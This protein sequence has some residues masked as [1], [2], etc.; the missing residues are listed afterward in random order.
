[1]KRI[2]S[3]VLCFA[4][5]FVFSSAVVTAADDAVPK[6]SAEAFVLY[7]ADNGQILC[8]KNENKKMK[9]ASTTKIMTSLLALEEA[10][11]LNKKVKFTE[12]MTA[13]GS[14][15]Y[16]KVGEVVTLKD[17]AAGMMM[18]SGNDAANATALT[19]SGST[20]KFSELMNGRANQ[21][22]MRNTHF[23]TPSGLDDD[24][25]YSTAFDMALLMAYALENEEFAQ[26]TSQKSVTVDFIEPA[27]KKTTYSNHNR[28]LSLYKY[29]IGGKTGYTMA[30]GRCL[31]SAAKKDG[32]TLVCVTMNDRN[33][34][35]DHASLYDYGFSQLYSYQ[36]EDSKFCVDVP[37]VGGTADKVA[38]MGEKD[39]PVIV[40]SEDKDKIVRKVYLDS[41]VY[42][43]IKA[44][45][46]V[47]K[48]EY[49]IDGKT[50]ARVNL[51]A[52]NDVNSQKENKSLFDI[53]K[54]L[55][56]YG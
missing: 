44:N 8:S 19:V 13:E 49:L 48:I 46:T 32:I 53:I 3:F 50:I 21:I 36:T 25:H 17:L 51:V 18:A 33:D 30:A 47:G 16:L 1:M 56:T 11:S 40:Q 28:L 45:Q 42:A 15:M 29:C 20:E 2:I 6:T 31:V 43:P 7:C 55:F 52:V 41:F 34:W 37:C 14:S 35:K 23:V 26:L 4:I 24:N 38:V 39:V 12:A 54:E 22:G 10:A 5:L 9:P 27:S